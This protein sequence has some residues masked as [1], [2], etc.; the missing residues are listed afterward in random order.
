M[1]AADRK[2]AWPLLD[3]PSGWAE[4][5]PHLSDRRRFSAPLLCLD[6]LRE[7][8]PLRRA[9]LFCPRSL[10][11]FACRA[12]RLRRLLV[13]RSTLLQSRITGHSYLLRQ[14]LNLSLLCVSAT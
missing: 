1:P 14:L 3:V 7:L 9:E 11:P 4:R 10:A 12:R 2:P 13:F 5:F 6:L 8:D